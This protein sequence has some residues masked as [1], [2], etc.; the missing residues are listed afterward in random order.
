MLRLPSHEDDRRVFTE[1][2]DGSLNPERLG[3]ALVGT[4]FFDEHPFAG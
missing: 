2:E 1:I 3:I 4:G